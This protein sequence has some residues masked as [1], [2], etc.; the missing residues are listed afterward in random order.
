MPRTYPRTSLPSPVGFDLQPGDV[1]T[2]G[3]TRHGADRRR[4][5]LS[6]AIST[7]AGA[8]VVV[9]NDLEHPV[10]PLHEV[11]LRTVYRNEVLVARA[12]YVLGP[13]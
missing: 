12:P 11:F 3:L 10:R 7:R 6:G 8:P 13:R 2:Y 9:P 5:I 4:T 1:V